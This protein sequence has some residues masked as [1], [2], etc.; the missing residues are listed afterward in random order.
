MWS[1]TTEGWRWHG[2][3]AEVG[4]YTWDRKTTY[5]V[6]VQVRQE[7]AEVQSGGVGRTGWPLGRLRAQSG[8]AGGEV[9][10]R[11]LPSPLTPE[12]VGRS[13]S[14]ILVD[15]RQFIAMKDIS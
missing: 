14:H 3:E 1:R 7:P 6:G 8:V 9:W 10:P 5:G 2:L 15:P 11:G 13:E 12:L 4:S